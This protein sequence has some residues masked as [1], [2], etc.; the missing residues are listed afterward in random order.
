[1]TITTLSATNLKVPTIRHDLGPVNVLV[2][3][4]YAGKSA[5]LDALRLGLLGW[6][7]GLPKTNQ[8]VWSLSCGSAMS[9]RLDLSDGTVIERTY[10]QSGQSIKATE[11]IVEAFIPPVLMDAGEYLRLSER[12]RVSLVFGLVDVSNRWTSY[13]IMREIG[14]TP[15]DIELAQLKSGIMSGIADSMTVL[16]EKGTVQDWLTSV[17]EK[18]RER[19][20][21]TAA[22]LARMEKYSQGAIELKAGDNLD[23]ANV[24]RILRDKS[25]ELKALGERLAVARS[26]QETVRQNATTRQEIQRRLAE[27]FDP[28]TAE[29]IRK[30][31][32]EV[33]PK[34]EGQKADLGYLSAK[35]SEAKGQLEAARARQLHN[36]TE[37]K[38]LAH[39]HELDVKAPKCP[40]CGQAGNK[41]KK[42][43]ETQFVRRTALLTTE[44]DTLHFEFE[45]AQ[46]TC[47]R[48]QSDYQTAA[49][50]D[51]E[52][53]S[54]RLLLQSLRGELNRLETLAAN[55]ATWQRQLDGLA[56]VEAP[57]AEDIL[58][59]TRAVTALGAE[60]GDLTDRQKRWIAQAHEAKRA[61]EAKS[62][63]QNL[64][65]ELV[66]LK[67]I[68][69]A[70]ES[71]QS[72]MVAQ[73]FGK[74]LADV[75]RFCGDG[76]L[77][78][79]IAYHQQEL[80][81]WSNQQPPVWIPHRSFSGT[82]SLIFA[83]GASAALAR[84]SPLKICLLD[85]L[86]R[87]D[88]RHKRQLMERLVFLTAEGFIDQAVCIDLDAAPY[89][90]ISGL[91]IIEI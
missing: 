34:V 89:R 37:L 91:N 38:A 15:V 90:D 3:D 1:M 21:N 75:N 28:A 67:A 25:A 20:R 85:E 55:R 31:I 51:K 80:G 73:A 71:V 43:I 53:Q 32:T 81:R 2:G 23:A 14:E 57:K 86:G 47:A 10:T 52:V 65:A 27:P 59:M 62:A 39:Q 46:K 24:D 30:Q 54:D 22:A 33:G 64:E 12:E 74:I 60:V 7:P 16:M 40:H 44:R 9:V 41:F 4:N 87:L 83:A 42:A 69:R 72:E 49:L 88:S 5:R 17:L 78:S 70:T 36:I 19:V 8:G 63:R 45:D 13:T 66:A 79:P 61:A 18:L 84:Q 68:V 82:E 48:N 6:C 29:A 58:T 76:L 77:L 26:Q 11:N 35:V 50:A 56:A